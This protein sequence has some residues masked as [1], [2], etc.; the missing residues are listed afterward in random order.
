MVT[1]LLLILILSTQVAQ[2]TLLFDGS[3]NPTD[4]NDLGFN[5][6]D[7][8]DQLIAEDFTFSN[9][10]LMNSITFLGSYYEADTPETDFFTLTVYHDL[11]GL[12]DSTSVVS[13]IVLGDLERTYTGVNF[14][15]GQK[16]YT[17][18]ADFSALNLLANT[19]YWITVVNDTSTDS[20]DDWAWAGDST[21]GIYGRS[22]DSGASW[23]DTL[24]GSFSFSIEGIVVPEPSIMCIFGL[25]IVVLFLRRRS[26]K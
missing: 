12:P 23:S 14:F 10:A 24:A 15:T 21:N 25:G 22:F 17:Y 11:L 4:V 1:P 26:N 20:D 9:D 16:L 8:P 19:N 7:Y 5:D 6:M 13:E 18:T 3:T 2:A